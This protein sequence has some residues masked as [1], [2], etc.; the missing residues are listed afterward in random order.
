MQKLT[1]TSQGLVLSYPTWLGLVVL[2]I[3]V[4]LAVYGA[5]G[6]AA[7]KMR[8]SYVIGTLAMVWGGVY[9]LTAKVTLTDAG[10]RN[11]VFLV[12]DERLEWRDAASLQLERRQAKGGPVWH[13]IVL[14]HAGQE[15]DIGTPGLSDADRSRVVKFIAAQV[16]Q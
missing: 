2:A 15:F 13:I 5:R 14:D 16:P 3:G 7:P 6:K 1:E 4:T 10:M 11:Y 12:K 8:L 9:V